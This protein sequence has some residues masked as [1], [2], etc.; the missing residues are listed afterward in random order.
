MVVNAWAMPLAEGSSMDTW[1]NKV[2]NLRKKVRGWTANVIASSNKRR[3]V[4]EEFNRLDIEAENRSLTD[5]EKNRMKV[6]AEEINRFW[7]LE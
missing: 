4:S 3:E 1:Q 5:S 6:L 7:A 2:R